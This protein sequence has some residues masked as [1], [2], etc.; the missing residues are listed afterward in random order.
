MVRSHT[1]T[2]LHTTLVSYQ[3][4]AISSSPKGRLGLS[5]G[6][7]TQ[8]CVDKLVI[9]R[10]IMCQGHHQWLYLCVLVVRGGNSMELIESRN[11]ESLFSHLALCDS[12]APW[13]HCSLPKIS[14]LYSFSKGGLWLTL[15]TDPEAWWLVHNSQ[16]ADPAKPSLVFCV[17]FYPT[18]SINQSPWRTWLVHPFSKPANLQGLFSA[19]NKEHIP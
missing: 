6:C 5:W 17:S 18:R 19:S 7:W 11:K 9:T 13:P 3:Q 15:A 14:L 8:D 10:G 1:S 4:C 2:S 12:V 16:S